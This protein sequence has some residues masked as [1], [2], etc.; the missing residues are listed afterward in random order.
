MSIL[1]WARELGLRCTPPVRIPAYPAEH[2]Y[3]VIPP[4]SSKIDTSLPYIRDFD[5]YSYVREWQGIYLFS[6]IF[7]IVLHIIDGY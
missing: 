1:Q 5:S 4:L 6:Y 7:N 2:L 3:A